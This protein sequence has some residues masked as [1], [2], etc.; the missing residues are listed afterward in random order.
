MSQKHLEHSVTLNN[1][2]YFYS[3]VPLDEEST[4]V[5]CDA[6]NISQPFAN[7]DI[8]ALLM[9]LPNLILAEKAYQKKQAEVIR[10]RVSI[11][12]KKAIERKAASEGYPTTS[13]FLRALALRN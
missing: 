11:E 10:F 4:F 8:P 9:D 5:E 7:E 6:A 13:A 3:L 12:E 2:K 1:R